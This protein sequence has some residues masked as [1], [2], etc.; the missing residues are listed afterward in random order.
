[1][2]L[3]EFIKRASELIGE[4]FEE[5]GS[6]RPMFHFIN[7]DGDDVVMLAPPDNDKDLVMGLVRAVLKGAAATR[8]VF[9]DEGWMV[10][11]AVNIE[12]DELLRRY[13]ARNHPRR[14][15]VVMFSG[16]DEHEGLVMATRK[17]VRKDT[18]RP[19]LGPLEFLSLLQGTTEGRLVGL[20]P[21][22]KL[23]S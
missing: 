14:I 13:G 12:D 6:I 4:R 16:E 22:R 17:I 23:Q 8:V 11:G 5:A 7:G 9:I 1:M 3:H 18:A 21:R 2:N 19:R 15:E 10:D 20:L